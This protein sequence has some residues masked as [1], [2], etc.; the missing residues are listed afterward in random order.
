MKCLKY[1]LLNK[2][3]S[4]LWAEQLHGLHKYKYRIY[5]GMSGLETRYKQMP[6]SGKFPSLKF[7]FSKR[8]GQLLDVTVIF[9]CIHNGFTG[10]NERSQ[11]KAMNKHQAI[12]Y[13]QLITLVHFHPFTATIREHIC[14]MFFT[15]CFC[16]FIHINIK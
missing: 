14:R 16:D 13:F 15:K 6:T 9:I 5:L 2:T 4:T 12:I 7:V 1:C 10:P 11:H 8:F 3:Q